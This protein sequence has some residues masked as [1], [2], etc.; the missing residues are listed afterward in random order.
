[1]TIFW[2]LIV[3]VGAFTFLTGAR[4]ADAAGVWSIY[5]V[6]LVFWSGLAA[7]GPAI[8]AMMQLTEAR[9]SPSVRRIALTTSGFLPVAFVLFLL[10]GLGGVTL[11]P[12]ATT[13]IPAKEPWLTWGFFWGRTWVGTGVLFL[14]AMR[15]VTALLKDAVPPDDERER[16]R[17]N[18]L[19]VVLLMLWVVVVSLW[20]FDLVMSLEP[21]WYSGLFGGY[22]V[23]STFYTTLCLLSILT[24]R[25][26]ARG[27]A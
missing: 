21:K 5:L 27:Q 13:P 11:Y 22:F 3:A 18:R 6:N 15:F 2:G 17:R 4:S 19:A 12:W 23:V 20:G 26:N 9:W 16:I 7:T 10:L 1:M 24:V 8:A 25:A 14:V